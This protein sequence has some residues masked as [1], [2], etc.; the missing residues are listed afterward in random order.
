[1]L[2]SHREV[3]VGGTLK[4]LYRQNLILHFKETEREDKS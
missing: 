1:M 2:G 3:E 4:Q